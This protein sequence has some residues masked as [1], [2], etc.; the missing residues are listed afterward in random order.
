MSFKD[1]LFHVRLAFVRSIAHFFQIFASFLV[2]DGKE[3]KPESIFGLAL[4]G[5]MESGTLLTPEQNEVLT[6][7]IAKLVKNSS[8][9]RPSPE[10][11]SD[12]STQEMKQADEIPMMEVEEKASER[13]DYNYKLQLNRQ[14]VEAAQEGLIIFAKYHTDLIFSQVI[15]KLLENVDPEQLLSDPTTV[16]DS[17]KALVLLSGS[18][19]GLFKSI[20]LS[21]MGLLYSNIN[22]LKFLET[23]LEIVSNCISGAPTKGCGEACFFVAERL[24]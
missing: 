19:S 18:A 17:L 15:P 21:L 13:L 4:L 1:N 12:D 16:T 5:S 22:N 8:T 10:T 20:M 24:Y 9:P 23:I 2:E 3:G 11:R 14:I 7:S 6:I